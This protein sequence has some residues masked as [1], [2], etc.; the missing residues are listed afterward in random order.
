MQGRM[1]EGNGQILSG[2]NG[3]RRAPEPGLVRSNIHRA[4][5][6]APPLVKWF[7]LML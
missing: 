6:I 4:T 3:G 5:T 1:Y 7:N 2:G